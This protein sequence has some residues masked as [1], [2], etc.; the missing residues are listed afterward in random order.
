MNFDALENVG[1][2]YFRLDRDTLDSVLVC[3]ICLSKMKKPV[4]TMCGHSFCNN[5]IFLHLLGSDRCPM[6]RADLA[7][8]Q[9]FPN[10]PLET[11]LA[12]LEKTPVMSRAAAA[13]SANPFV[14]GGFALGKK[15]VGDPPVRLPS[16]GAAVK[17]EFH[18]RRHLPSCCEGDENLFGGLK[19]GSATEAC[20][21][22][23]VL[24]KP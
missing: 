13:F 1:E 18:R 14:K 22:V 21:K 3:P 15:S 8:S 9:V 6:C 19:F 16:D 4:L 20:T 17:P 2:L 23:A 10:R 24:Q 5:C 7:H 12:Y 11:I